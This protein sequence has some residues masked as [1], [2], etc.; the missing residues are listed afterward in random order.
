[1]KRALAILLALFCAAC[2]V[3]Q[4]ERRAPAADAATRDAAHRELIQEVRIGQVFGY[5]WRYKR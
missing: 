5:G 4:A 2:S 3:P 1:M